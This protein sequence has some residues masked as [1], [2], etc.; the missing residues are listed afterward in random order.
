MQR[1]L[2]GLTL[3]GLTLGSGTVLTAGAPHVGELAQ[4]LSAPHRW[5]SLVGPD[6]AMATLAGA[7]LWLVAAWVAVSLALAAGSLLPGRLGTAVRAIARR[8]TPAALR[9][10]VV[11]AAGASILLAPA[12]AFASP[13]A[14]PAPG[15]AV[16]ATMPAIGWPT[17]PSPST[18]AHS[19]SPAPFAPS[20][21]PS[22]GRIGAPRPTS[23]LIVRPGDSLWSIA[24]RRL[25][26][27]P[28]AARIE[29]EWP[30][31]YAA[32]RS[33]IGAD[34][35]LILPGSRLVVPQPGPTGSGS[36]EAGA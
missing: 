13:A 17:D 35:G 30:R 5:I 7:L 24:A 1:Q 3:A 19:A 34:P 6:A 21:S 2:S 25:G 29:Q 18:A 28:S 11:T 22:T 36:Q 8:C 20:A 10:V 14:S 9:R 16:S 23:R 4:D 31:W 33:A 32:N 27:R 26:A 12:T 15:G